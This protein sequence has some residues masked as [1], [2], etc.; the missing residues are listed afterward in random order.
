MKFTA[1][2]GIKA[3]T[4]HVFASDWE[5]EKT[6]TVYG[7]NGSAVLLMFYKDITVDRLLTITEGSNPG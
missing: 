2:E 7:Y 1:D 3:I 4:A 6:L 5:P